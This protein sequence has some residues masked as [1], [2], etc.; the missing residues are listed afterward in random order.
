MDRTGDGATGGGGA[1][2]A[3]DATTGAG[4]AASV[5]GD[6][7]GA[8][9]EKGD[10]DG[11]GD[12]DSK[13][14]EDMAEED[15]LVDELQ[16]LCDIH[17]FFPCCLMYTK[18]Y[19]HMCFGVSVAMVLVFAVAIVAFAATLCWELLQW[20]QASVHRFADTMFFVFLVIVVVVMLGATCAR[21]Y[22]E[23]KSCGKSPQKYYERRWRC[24]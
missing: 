12:G 11:D 24:D 23:K 20:K 16:T 8:A 15:M 21:A 9:S 2:T 17:F 18:Y 3:T 14:G 13:T 10:G 7:G 19:S 5:S 6:A 22:E 1:A 4:G